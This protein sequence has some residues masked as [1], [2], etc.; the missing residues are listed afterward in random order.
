VRRHRTAIPLTLTL[1]TLLTTL[2]N[3]LS[4]VCTG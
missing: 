4:N 2:Y 1:M 3:V